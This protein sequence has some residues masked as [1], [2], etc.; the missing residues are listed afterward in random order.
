MTIVL[1]KY[2]DNV[3]NYNLYNEGFFMN[4]SRIALLSAVFCAT[5]IFADEIVVVTQPGMISNIAASVQNN[6]RALVNFIARYTFADVIAG[7]SVNILLDRLANCLQDGT[8]KSYI[9]TNADNVNPVGRLMVLSA[10]AYATYKAIQAYNEQNTD[11]DD[12][13]IFIDEE[14]VD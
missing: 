11:N 14:Y 9:Q 8:I 3:V 4:I 12:D 10:G 2:I 5:S 7:Y 13:I 1:C 6:S